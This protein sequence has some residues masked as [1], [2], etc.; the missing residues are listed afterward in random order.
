MAEISLKAKRAVKGSPRVEQFASNAIANFG[1]GGVAVELN[2]QF[3]V[4]T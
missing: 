2:G 1:R 3:L 4:N